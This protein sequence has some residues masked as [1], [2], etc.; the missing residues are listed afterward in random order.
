MKEF[1]KAELMLKAKVAISLHNLQEQ[2][3]MS[4][5]LEETQQFDSRE[6]SLTG[7]ANKQLLE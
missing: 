2:E 3:K 1:R 6:M 7:Y 5:K 4:K